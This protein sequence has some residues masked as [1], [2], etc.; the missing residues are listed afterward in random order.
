MF[1]SRAG[2]P[3]ENIAV[4]PRL[5]KESCVELPWPCFPGPEEVSGRLPCSSS[6]WLCFVGRLYGPQVLS[7]PAPLSRTVLV[8]RSRH[9]A[10]LVRVQ[11]STLAVSPCTG[12]DLGNL[13]AVS[14]EFL[15][16]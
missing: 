4:L 2:C 5:D 14:F 8:R 16:D 3:A 9:Q 1:S 15:E 13:L 7:G 11:H 6:S 10:E 12:T